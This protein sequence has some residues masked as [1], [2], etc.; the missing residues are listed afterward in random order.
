MREGT[1]FR[2][3]GIEVEYFVFEKTHYTRHMPDGSKQR[4]DIKGRLIAK[5]DKF[6]NYLKLIYEGEN[7]R[8]VEDN[9]GRKLNFFYVQGRNKVSEIRGP[10]NLKV[11]YSYVNLDDLSSVVNAWGN[12]Y[13]YE[14]D[15]L[16]NLTKATWPDNTFISI[17]YDTKNDWV[18]S[19]TDRDKCVENYTYEFSKTDPKNNYWATVKKTCA[20]ELVSENRYE[21]WHKQRPDGQVYLSKVQQIVNGEITEVTYHEIFGKPLTIRRNNQKTSFDYYPDG[22]V[23]TKSTPSLKLTFKYHPENK[24]VTQVESQFYDEKGKPTVKRVSTFDYDEKGN[25]TTAKN[26]DGMEVR[27][28]FDSKG[29]ISTITDHAKRTVLLEYD[30]R[31]GKQP[32][33]VTR[34][35]VGTITIKYNA[36]GEIQDVQSPDGL[37]VATQVAS[38]FNNLL[39]V[40]APASTDLYL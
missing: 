16:H 5:Y 12:K 32:V 19:F 39:D 3:N 14:Y 23:K 38:T 34:P 9:N 11:T 17:R 2:A 31:F 6:G 26:S 22:L 21:F 13:T 4:F 15:E 25:I 20:N 1:R 18:I 10:G 33:K 7:L 24:K 8:T 35:G 27:M 29:R 37:G 28:T 30:E 36:K 40:V